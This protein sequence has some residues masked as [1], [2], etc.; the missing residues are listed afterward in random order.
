VD[1]VG[2]EIVELLFKYTHGFKVYS[3]DGRPYRHGPD[4]HYQL[5]DVSTAPGM[6]FTKEQYES[7]EV[8]RWVKGLR[9]D[10]ALTEIAVREYLT[11][12]EEK[13][14]L[15]VSEGLTFVLHLLPGGAAADYLSKGEGWNAGISIAADFALL[16]AG[17]FAKLAK[18][19]KGARL[20]RIAAGVTE[21]GVGAIRIY[22][23]F[24]AF[25]QGD[26]IEAAGYFG[27]AILRLLGAGVQL[28]AARSVNPLKGLPR[29]GNALKRDAYHA[30]PDVVDNFATDATAFRLRPG[31]TL[32]QV[33]GSLNGVPGRFEWIVDKGKVTHRFFVPG[34]KINGIPIKP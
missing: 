34:G 12:E 21:T 16:A 3:I 19:A 13:L 4:P 10:A 7:G 15:R 9:A 23:G 33:E 1:V 27:E 29:V 28:R 6:L 2:F 8:A 32:Y 31:T 14:W 24:D 30:F 26:K 20:W 5:V 25:A 17:P 11:A 22:Q 18:T